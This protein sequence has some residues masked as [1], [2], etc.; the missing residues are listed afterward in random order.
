MKARINSLV[1]SIFVDNI[2]VINAKNLIYIKE[3][4]LKLATTFQIIDI[5]LISFY[6]RLK[7]KKNRVKKTL[8]LLQSAYI[9]KILTKY[10]FDQAKFCNT[11]I[12]KNILLLN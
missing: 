3:F 1:I 11:L 9:D 10:H 6:L 2:K 7:I 4:K 12:K 5:R 8:Q